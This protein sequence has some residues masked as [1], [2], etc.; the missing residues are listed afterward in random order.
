MPNLG[1]VSPNVTASK[2]RITVCTVQKTKL[3]GLGI[4]GS[5]GLDQ[6]AGLPCQVGRIIKSFKLEKTFESNHEPSTVKSTLNHVPKGQIYVL[7]K[8]LQR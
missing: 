7:L 3:P 4:R 1:D 6:E 2:C 8:Y 5:R